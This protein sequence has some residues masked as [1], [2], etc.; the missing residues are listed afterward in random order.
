LFNYLDK[1]PTLYEEITE[2]N[3]LSDIYNLLDTEEKKKFF[4]KLIDKI[5]KVT[6]SSNTFAFVFEFYKR[7]NLLDKK[8]IFLKNK[9]EKEEYSDNFDK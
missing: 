2:I 4:I 5:L 7:N 3:Y 1:I 8:R 6:E 9:L